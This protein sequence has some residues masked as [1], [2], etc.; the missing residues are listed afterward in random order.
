MKDRVT[1]HDVARA[2]GVSAATVSYVINEREDQSISEETKQK[3]WHVIN[4]LNYKPSVFAK[5]LR[6][7]P[8]SKLIAV[9]TGDLNSLARAEYLFM[10]E[11]FIAAFPDDYGLLFNSI[12]C[13]RVENADAIIAYNVSKETFYKIGNKN[14]V[15]LVAVDCLVN[16]SLFFQVTTDYAALKREAESAFPNGYSFVCIMPSD[17]GLKEEILEC[18]PNAIFAQTYDD[19]CAVKVKN[20]VTLNKVVADFFR[21]RDVN[22]FFANDAYTAKCT[23]TTR[24]IEQALSH[25]PFDI[26]SYKV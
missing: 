20:A 2:A 3:I 15:P 10:L 17:E 24:C 1:I 22:L 11:N 5:N 12:S 7:A 26:H 4:L 21:N 25:E 9:C 23:Q 6:A 8:H 19:L 13:R 16:D 14:Y 18:F